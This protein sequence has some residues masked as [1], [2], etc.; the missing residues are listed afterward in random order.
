MKNGTIIL[1]PRELTE[2][3]QISERTLTMIDK[4]MANMERG[5]VSEP[6][7]LSDF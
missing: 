2:P 3:F 7:D 4:A 1:D 6:V 5:I